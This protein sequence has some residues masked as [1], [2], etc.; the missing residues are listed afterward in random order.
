MYV[1]RIDQTARLDF[2]YLI[3][4]KFAVDGPVY[5]WY[6]ITDI[7]SISEKRES[8]SVYKLSSPI[9]HVYRCS[10][11]SEITQI[12]KDDLLALVFRVEVNMR[13]PFGR[14][15]CSSACS[16]SGWCAGWKANILVLLSFTSLLSARLSSRVSLPKSCL[17]WYDSDYYSIYPE[18]R[19]ILI[20]PSWQ[21]RQIQSSTDCFCPFF[22]PEHAGY[23][24]ARNPW[25]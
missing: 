24:R 17:S 10:T 23:C 6:G 15:C 14:G 2:K 19:A 16:K 11:M 8:L 25:F 9:S 4:S 3:H 21:A 12:K 20:S 13:G 22:I 18:R 1:Q 5:S 7:R